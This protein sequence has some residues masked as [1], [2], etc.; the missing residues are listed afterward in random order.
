MHIEHLDKQTILALIAVI[1]FKL[2]FGRCIFVLK[3]QLLHV[4]S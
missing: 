4:V 1:R 2:G 3:R